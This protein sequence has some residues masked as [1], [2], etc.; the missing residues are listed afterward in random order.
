MI[1]KVRKDATV[2][3]LFTS[4]GSL[5]FSEDYYGEYVHFDIYD[6]KIEETKRFMI[7]ASELESIATS[8]VL[9]GIVDPEGLQKACDKVDVQVLNLKM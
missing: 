2:G 3:E 8:A 9:L 1:D 4:H 7:S 5:R 6:S